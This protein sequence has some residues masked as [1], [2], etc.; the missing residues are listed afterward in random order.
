MI[1][2]KGW[3]PASIERRFS[4]SAPESYDS[5]AHSCTAC[6]S[7]GAAVKRFYGTEILTISQ[8]AVDLSRLPVAVLDSHSQTSVADVL[9]RIDSAWISGGQLF[10]R[11]I[12]AQTPRGRVAEG[13][14]GRGELTGISAGYRVDKWSVTDSDGDVVDPARADWDDDLTF[15]A[16]KWT[17]LETSLVGIPADSM[18]AVRSYGAGGDRQDDI[19]DVRMLM[20]VRERM[21]TRQRMHEAAQALIGNRND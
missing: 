7:S 17:L 16:M 21:A 18:A 13:M 5:T 10:G 1:G 4:T 12:F 6:I 20:Q 15:T 11:I 14:V 8:D 3:S 9:G 19:D 2:P